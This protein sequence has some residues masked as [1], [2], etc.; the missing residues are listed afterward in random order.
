MGA[1]QLNNAK[2]LLLERELFSLNFMKL[3]DHFWAHNN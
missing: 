3:P 2:V 1:P